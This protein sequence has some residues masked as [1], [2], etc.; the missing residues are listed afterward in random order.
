MG[1]YGGGRFPRSK[2]F[3][4]NGKASDISIKT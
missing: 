4:P 1:S 3:E 2:L